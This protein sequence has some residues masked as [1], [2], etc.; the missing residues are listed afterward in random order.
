MRDLK[1]TDETLLE[2]ADLLR[3]LIKT[4]KERKK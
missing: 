2:I 3:E 1:P 4:L